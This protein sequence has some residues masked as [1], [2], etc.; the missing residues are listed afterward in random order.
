VPGERSL[1][2]ATN[3][4]NNLIPDLLSLFPT[5]KTLIVYSDLETF[6]LSHMGEM[7]L[8]A[9]EVRK[10]LTTIAAENPHLQGQAPKQLFFAT[11][12]QVAA[13]VWVMQMDYLTGV[14]Q[15]LSPD[16]VRTLDGDA[17]ISDPRSILPKLTSFFGLPLESVSIETILS[18][19]LM[20]E[21]SKLPS[22]PFSP[23]QRRQELAGR[24]ERYRDAL[25]TTMRWARQWRASLKGRPG[26]SN[27][28]VERLPS[29][30]ET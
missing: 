9:G 12:L 1:I 27:D 19:P 21:Y 3:F 24:R 10:M 28:L 29:A 5:A 14:L 20:S 4:V 7:Q 23:E 30:L 22:Q 11:D 25:E 8:R 18:G 17:F 13:M 15:S 2:K 26:L 6:L 16:K